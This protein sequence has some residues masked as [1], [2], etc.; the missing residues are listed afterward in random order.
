VTLVLSRRLFANGHSD[1]SSSQRK[2][3]QEAL[4]DAATLVT[5]KLQV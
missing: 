1:I 5:A 2:P 4:L 3:E